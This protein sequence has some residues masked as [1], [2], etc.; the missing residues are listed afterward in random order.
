[1]W[2]VSRNHGTVLI[3]KGRNGGDT[4]HGVG[5]PV[6]QKGWNEPRDN[7]VH[8]R[9]TRREGHQHQMLANRCNG[10]P[11]TPA[12]HAPTEVV[13]GTAIQREAG[14]LS[15]NSG[16][17]PASGPNDSN[18]PSGVCGHLQPEPGPLLRNDGHTRNRGHTTLSRELPLGIGLSLIQREAGL[19]SAGTGQ[20]DQGRNIP[21]RP[22]GKATSGLAVCVHLTVGH[23]APLP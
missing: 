17:V 20:T 4:L 2:T 23:T 8:L 11:E 12:S 13:L 14:L 1:M 9:Q 7:W 3:T 18:I 5:W 10:Q 21:L 6:W 22:G 19:Q 16:H 15:H